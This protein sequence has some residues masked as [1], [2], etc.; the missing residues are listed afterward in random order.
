MSSFRNANNSTSVIANQ[1]QGTESNVIPVYPTSQFPLSS[2]RQEG[3]F[4]LNSTTGKLYVNTIT[5]KFNDIVISTA[6][7]NNYVKLYKHPPATGYDDFF[8]TEATYFTIESFVS[9]LNTA[10]AGRLQWYFSNTDNK[11]RS[12]SISGVTEYMVFLNF[13]FDDNSGLAPIIGWPFMGIHAINTDWTNAPQATNAYTNVLGWSEVSQSTLPPG[14]YW[15]MDVGNNLKNSN[16]GKVL[17]NTNSNSTASLQTDSMA[18]QNLNTNGYV[19]NDNLGIL[20]T[21]STIPSS[22]VVINQNL[23]MLGYDITGCGKIS[24]TGELDIRNGSTGRFKAEFATN[25]VN[26]KSTGFINTYE[27]SQVN[28][29]TPVNQI[30]NQNNASFP[31]YF[32]VN[33]PA[34]RIGFKTVP[35][36][37]SKDFS[38]NGDLDITGGNLYLQNLS[39]TTGQNYLILN[40][41]KSVS[42]AQITTSNL[43]SDSN[44]VINSPWHFRSNNNPTI[45]HDLVNLEYL[46]NNY[47][48]NAELSASLANVAY[49]NVQNVFTT[50]QSFTGSSGE[51]LRLSRGGAN[52]DYINFVTNSGVQEGYLGFGSVGTNDFSVFNATTGNLLF[53]TN[54]LERMRIDTSGNVGIGKTPYAS[55]KLD[56]NGVCNLEQGLLNMKRFDTVSGAEIN[57][58][59]ADNVGLYSLNVEGAN[60]A[61]QNLNIYRN[62]DVLMTIANNGNIGIGITG[63]T[64]KL[65]VA[66]DNGI[67]KLC[68]SSNN[69]KEIQIGID[70]TNNYGYIASIWQGISWRPLILNA[71]GSN[72]GIGTTTPIY[73][74]DVNGNIRTSSTVYLGS[75]GLVECPTTDVNVSNSAGGNII[76]GP[77]VGTTSQKVRINTSNGYVGVGVVPTTKFEVV[78]NTT[79]IGSFHSTDSS[80]VTR[81]IDIGT[82]TTTER[83]YIGWETGGGGNFGTVGIRGVSGSIRM[84]NSGIYPVSIGNSFNPNNS[85]TLNTGTINSTGYYLNGNTTSGLLAW[86]RITGSTGALDTTYSR[87]GI[88]SGTRNGTGSYTITFNFTLRTSGSYPV[89]TVSGI[90]NSAAI[91]ANAYNYDAVNNKVNVYVFTSNT[92]SATDNDFYIHVI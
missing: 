60:P 1:I 40:S 69:N 55:Y 59:M 76:L 81:V 46:Q 47:V 15:Q 43:V 71:G 4:A 17:V 58:N 38:F 13:P 6:N 35:N 53:G 28:F 5:E 72:V 19:K 73:A 32:G 61:S 88:T 89:I 57:M 45:N 79:F 54:N 63:P 87:G 67:I 91:L 25:E 48:D 7:H 26:L 11:F 56:V 86:G 70:T 36:G 3:C 82:N 18:V 9:A 50:L 41:D 51:R 39:Y 62:N 33:Q 66:Q 68:G 37:A 74:L 30:S 16:L 44:L 92:G 78:D 42:P 84:S 65:H 21:S 77:V 31:T 90:S 14:E 24:S 20:S 23:N 29:T 34:H 52:H 10:C 12:K 85:Y 64:G 75:G 83:V 27:D 22:D 2:T 80:S 49:T 8:I